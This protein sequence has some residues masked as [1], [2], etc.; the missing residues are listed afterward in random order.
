[1]ANEPDIAARLERAT[2][3]L[4]QF[5]WPATEAL[6]QPILD[7]LGE[8]NVQLAELREQVKFVGADMRTRTDVIFEK[9]KD[10]DARLKGVEIGVAGQRCKDH[11]T[12]LRTVETDLEVL[13]GGEFPVRLRSLESWAARVAGGLAVLIVVADLGIRVWGLLR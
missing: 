3:A 12:R 2:A 11:S 8:V 4:E 13:R 6:H 1:M 9:H 7:R 10:H 5:K